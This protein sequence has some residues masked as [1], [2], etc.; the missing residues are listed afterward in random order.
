MQIEVISQVNITISEDDLKQMVL[1]KIQAHDPRIE[2][3]K[4]EITQKR[5]PTRIEVDVDAQLAGSNAPS[6][7]VSEKVVA[8]IEETKA[9]PVVETEEVDIDALVDGV[10]SASEESTFEEDQMSL[11][12]E[13]LAE[14]A[15]EDE[16]PFETETA[17]AP[18][19][20]LA[21]LL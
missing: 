5:S 18:S 14:T 11:I 3:K 10:E 6:P 20:S 21:D 19:Q 17:P 4:I 2:V 15:D 13:T 1:E 7:K 12:D 16:V 8:M 9:E